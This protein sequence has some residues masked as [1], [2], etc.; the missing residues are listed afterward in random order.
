MRKYLI[1]TDNMADLPSSYLE[2]H[3]IT[4]LSLSYTIDGK[5]YDRSNELPVKEFYDKMRAGSMPTTSQ[6]NPE[7]ANFPRIRTILPGIRYTNLMP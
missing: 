3:E 6:V 4:E 2:E 7:N 5:T 1:F